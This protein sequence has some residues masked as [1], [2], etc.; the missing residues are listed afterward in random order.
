VPKKIELLWSLAIPMPALSGD[1]SFDQDTRSGNR[2]LGPHNEL[3]LKVPEHVSLKSA[4][5][6]FQAG[7]RAGLSGRQI[8]A[9]NW[10]ASELSLARGQH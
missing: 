8:S 4:L 1:C 10:S 2:N 6:L 3:H 5:I 7:L 9:I